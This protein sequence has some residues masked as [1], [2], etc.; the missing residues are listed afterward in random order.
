VFSDTYHH[1]ACF[2]DKYLVRVHD[3]VQSVGYCQ[4]CAMLKFC[5]D[6]SLDQGIC[7]VKESNV[8][9]VLYMSILLTHMQDMP[10]SVKGCSEYTELLMPHLTMYARTTHC[11]AM[12]SVNFVN[13]C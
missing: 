4:Y 3:G 12:N 11:I 13:L 1:D 6:S 9:L 5:S 8:D 7:S 10:A 2:H